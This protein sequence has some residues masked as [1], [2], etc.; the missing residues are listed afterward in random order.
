VALLTLSKVKDILRAETIFGAELLA[1]IEVDSCYSADLMSD[2]LGRAKANGI[3]VTGLSNVQAVRTAE[4]ADIK[5]VCLVRGKK[6][7]SNMVELAREKNI[8]LLVTKLTMFE[9]C[10]LL[11]QA[12]LR[13]VPE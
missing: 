1:G 6:P 9:A 8:P 13:G 2:V 4:V 5:A 12:G 11:Y 10:G 7:D 3:L